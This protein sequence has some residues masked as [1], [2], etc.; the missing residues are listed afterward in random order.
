MTAEQMNLNKFFEL[1]IGHEIV[2]WNGMEIIPDHLSNPL[3]VIK[4]MEKEMPGVW[5]RYLNSIGAVCAYNYTDNM[6]DRR[7]YSTIILKQQLNLSNL[8]DYLKE[9]R[10]WGMKECWIDNKHWDCKRKSG[11]KFHL[12]Y[13][14]WEKHNCT[15]YIKH[16]ALEYLEGMA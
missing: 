14:G 1:F 5:E 15:G 2:K 9:N 10:E 16:P 7:F 4:W 8:V 3:P 12:G 11:C 13:R 6:L